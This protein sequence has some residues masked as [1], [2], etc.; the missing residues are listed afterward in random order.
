VK[1]APR[2]IF[3][4]LF[5]LLILVFSNIIYAED[6]FVV[7]DYEMS[8]II[9]LALMKG[10]FDEGKYI[11][12]VNMLNILEK[13]DKENDIEFN[14]DFELIRWSAKIS[15]ALGKK[16]MAYT[17][18]ASIYLANNEKN[19]VW[20]AKSFLFSKDPDFSQQYLA[21]SAATEKII[22]DEGVFSHPKETTEVV[23]M[24]SLCVAC[25]RKLDEAKLTSYRDVG[26]EAFA[27]FK[28][29][30]SKISDPQDL[31][32]IGCLINIWFLE[33]SMEADELYIQEEK[34][35]NWDPFV[36][37]PDSIKQH[38]KDLEESF[39]KYN[40]SR[41][42]LINVYCKSYVENYKKTP[43]IYM[44]YGR[45]QFRLGVLTQ[46][47]AMIKEALGNLE[48]A[49]QLKPIS[50]TQDLIN[51]AKLILGI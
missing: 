29:Q 38:L 44:R 13:E 25:Q 34:T 11:D 5:V 31:T 46:D 10:Y 14:E 47:K 50:L 19:E 18:S 21:D 33:I 49:Y 37:V 32:V 22:I 35:F 6:K 51:Q 8:R 27:S 2:S 43:D 4:A 3:L 12:A 41:Y 17:L 39:N 15:N 7:S 36:G 40:I 20:D 23:K 24:I 48:K 16:V 30:F 1:Q 26:S 9:S 45:S 28:Q 42:Q